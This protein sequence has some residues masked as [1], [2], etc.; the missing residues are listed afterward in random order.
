MILPVLTA[1]FSLIILPIVAMSIPASAP[2]NFFEYIDSEEASGVVVGGL[3][4]T[5]VS[6]GWTGGRD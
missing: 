1:V 2:N 5:G 6:H 4:P 3:A